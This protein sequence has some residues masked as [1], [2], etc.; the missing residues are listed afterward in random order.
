MYLPYKRS[1]LK[2]TA[3]LCGKIDNLDLSSKDE[4][5]TTKIHAC[6]KKV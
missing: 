6:N 5:V 4:M 3:K 1:H 2:A